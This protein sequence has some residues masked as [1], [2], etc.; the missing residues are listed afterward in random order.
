MVRFFLLIILFFTYRV[1]GTNERLKDFI[2]IEDSVNLD[3]IGYNNCNMQTNGEK[4]VLKAIQ[5]VDIV[6]DVGA[7]KGEW[8]LNVV[9]QQQNVTIYGFEPLPML[10]ENLQKALEKYHFSLVPIALSDTSGEKQFVYYEKLPGMS[11]LHQRPLQE[12]QLEMIPYYLTVP[13]QRLDDFCEKNN[14]DRINF[15]KIDTE[16]NEAAVLLGCEKMLNAKAIDII[17]FEYGG[18][19]IDSKTTLKQIYDYLT[20]RGYSI[21]RIYGSGLIKV[22][23]WRDNLENYFYCNYLAALDSST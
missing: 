18:C 9:L 12:T 4:E 1:E 14:I 16:G 5:P 10:W 21:Y 11:T 17:Q 20:Q 6:I 7:H 3:G 2:I 19:Y 13:T 23:I 22:S 8:S 15:I